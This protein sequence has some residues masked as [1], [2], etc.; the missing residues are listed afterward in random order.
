MAYQR[1]FYAARRMIDRDVLRKFQIIL[2]SNIRN[3]EPLRIG[4]AF[5]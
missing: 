2:I 4:P 1:I 3:S 5:I